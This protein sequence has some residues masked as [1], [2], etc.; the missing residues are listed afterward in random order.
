[1]E[2]EEGIYGR[3]GAGKSKKS[4][5]EKLLRGGDVYNRDSLLNRDVRKKSKVLGAGKEE[6]LLSRKELLGEKDIYSSEEELFGIEGDE[7]IKHE[8][9]IKKRHLKKPY[10]EE[11]DIESTLL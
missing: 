11:E 4:S 8:R 7:K 5:L 9:D 2:E 10:I 3:A 1:M 6:V